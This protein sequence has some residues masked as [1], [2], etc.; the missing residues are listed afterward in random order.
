MRSHMEKTKGN[1]YKLHQQK[2]HTDKRNNFFTVRTITHWNNLPREVVKVSITEGF[3]DAI[4]QGA[5]Q[6][7]PGSLSH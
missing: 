2:F 6:P 7:Y 3:Q 5:R 1:R 4:G